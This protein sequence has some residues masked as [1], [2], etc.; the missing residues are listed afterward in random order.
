MSS[1]WPY[2]IEETGREAVIAEDPAPVF[3]CW[4]GI[5]AI[6]ADPFL[7]VE[8]RHPGRLAATPFT[9]QLP[10]THPAYPRPENQTPATTPP[11]YF[12]ASANRE[13]FSS[14]SF[15]LPYDLRRQFNMTRIYINPRV[16]VGYDWSHYIWYKYIT[17]HWLVRWWMQTWEKGTD[18]RSARM[19]IGELKNVWEWDGGECQPVCAQVTEYLVWCSLDF[20]F[21]LVVKLQ[22]SQLTA[23]CSVLQVILATMPESCPNT[24]A[25]IS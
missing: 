16:I 5:V 8:L 14:E 6:K 19:V 22:C 7:P 1:V 15:N 11:I 12:R 25:N 10:T 21:L 17:R 4:N 24:Y 9:E 13:C 2:L 3:T 23:L 20:L 18:L